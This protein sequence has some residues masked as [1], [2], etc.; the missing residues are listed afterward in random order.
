MISDKHGIAIMAD[1]EEAFDSV[2][3]EGA[4]C[5]LYNV[6]MTN[7]LLLVLTSF[8]KHCQY[9]LS[10]LIFLVY[11]VD[12]TPEEETTT[13]HELKESKYA[14]DFTFWKTPFTIFVNIQLG[15][16]YGALNGKYC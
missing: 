16:K 10:P 8:L 4:I 6:V 9:R 7:N 15:I 13:E 2:W 1:L 3:R 11:T 5:K 14:E 12:M